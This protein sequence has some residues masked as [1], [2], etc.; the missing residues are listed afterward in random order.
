MKTYTFIDG[1]LRIYDGTATPFYLEIPFMQANFT[2]PEGNPRP[3]EIPRMN[4]GRVRNTDSNW[5]YI[6]APDDPIVNPVTLSFSFLMANN[7]PNYQKL[8]QALNID[9]A[10]T[11]TVGSNTWVSSKG[12]T[13]V[14]GGGRTPTLVTTPSFGDA[15]KRTVT[16]YTLWADPDGGANDIG[17]KWAEVYFPPDKQTIREAMDMVEI[18]CQGLIYGA[19]GQITAF[20]AGN[21]G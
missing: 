6:S 19:I 20:P 18:Q 14:L 9:M 7:Q 3:D 1:V 4:R 15:R 2:G 10:S 8:R 16:I 11:W 17:R 13:Q 12:T 21:A 5:H